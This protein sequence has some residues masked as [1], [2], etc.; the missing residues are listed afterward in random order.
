MSATTERPVILVVDDD[1]E[2]CELLA[3]LLEHH[4]YATRRA[5]SGAECLALVAREPVTLLLLDV[6]MPGLD[7]FAVCRRL[8]TLPSGRRPPVILLTG[9]DDLAVRRQGIR[10]GVCEFLTKPVDPEALVARIRTQLRVL[11]LARRLEGVERWLDG[12][13]AAAPA[14]TGR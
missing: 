9:Y 6:V 4:G 11:A 2:T 14:L 5:T 1:A 7:G 8:R 10:H 12:G 3:E 13:R